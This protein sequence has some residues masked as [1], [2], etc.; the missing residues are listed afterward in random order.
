M[1]MKSRPIR[2]NPLAG[3]DIRNVL[4][5]NLFCFE[6][7]I[8][9]IGQP[10]NQTKKGVTRREKIIKM[11]IERVFYFYVIYIIVRGHPMPT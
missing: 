11:C 8:Q 7:S 6:F 4:V 9:L 3:I 1:K 2:F 10:R 5:Q